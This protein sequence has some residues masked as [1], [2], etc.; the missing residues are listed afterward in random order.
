[1]LT[2]DDVNLYAAD[3][4]G[5]L[6]VAVGK[7]FVCVMPGHPQEHKGAVLYW[8]DTGDHASHT[9]KYADDHYDVGPRFYTLSEV[10]AARNYGVSR[11]LHASELVVWQLRL[12]VAAGVILPYPVKARPL[13]DDVPRHVKRLY[14]GIVELFACRWLHTLGDPTPFTR[15][16]A[17]AWCGIRSVDQIWQAMRWL[18]R[19]GYLRLVGYHRPKAGRKTALY[20]LGEGLR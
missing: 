7:K 14:H 8:N 16:F 18:Q 9:L 10:F 19:S 11:R 2:R 6:S 4:L 20:Q 1:M 17:Q 5:L 12:L 3:Y 13:P 15:D